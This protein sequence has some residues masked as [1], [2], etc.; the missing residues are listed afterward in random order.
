M[1]QVN[2]LNSTRKGR[3]EEIFE[4]AC[5]VIREKGFHQA[6]ITDIAKHAGISYGLVYHYFKSKSDLFDAILKTWWEGLF[7][8]MDAVD[9]GDSVRNR[10]T[11]VVY[12]FLD[13]FEQRSDL[14]YIFITEIS[15]SA[16]NLTPQRVELVKIFFDKT[17]S[18]IR[19]A[20]E[21]EAIRSDVDARYLTYIFLGSL[22]SFVSAMMLENRS[23]K[24][25]LQKQR[26]AKGILDVFFDGARA[27]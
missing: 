22:E 14:V 5:K 24:N 25:E 2:L 18:I 21:D 4:A 8:A 9:S 12:Y 23:L 13:L 19:R 20:Q 16:A 7:R 6:R 17:E 10:L 27:Q 3:E 15:R 1:D 26:I 11:A